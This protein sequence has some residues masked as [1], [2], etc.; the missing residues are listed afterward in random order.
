MRSGS[1]EVQSASLPGSAGPDTT[2]LRT[3]F[4]AAFS[5]ACAFMIASMAIFSPASGCCAS[6]MPNESF[7]SP[8]TN[9]A[10][11]REASRSLVWPANCGSCILTDST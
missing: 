5:R 4:C 2:R 1:C 11:S 10:D 3:T 6:Q 7:T 9:A 8:E